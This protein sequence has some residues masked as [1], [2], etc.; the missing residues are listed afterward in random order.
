[1]KLRL[2]GIFALVLLTQLSVSCGGNS[3]KSDSGKNSPKP[4]PSQGTAKVI[5]LA[6]L[7]GRLKWKIG[8]NQNITHQIPPQANSVVAGKAVKVNSSGDMPWSAFTMILF[9]KGNGSYDVLTQKRA[10][11][12]AGVIE[13]PGG[14]L[15]PGQSWAQGAVDEVMQEAGV[16]LTPNDLIFLQLNGPA[17]SQSGHHYGNVNFVAAF[18]NQRPDAPA[19]SSET[20]PTYGHKWL[21]LKATYDEMKKETQTIG[22]R[23]QGKYYASFRG[24]LIHFCQ[25]VLGWN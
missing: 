16:K 13:S 11:K 18:E 14:H 8:T 21:D 10:H 22:K 9:D 12:P 2:S 4:T 24:H 1:M 17:L 25:N 20:D 7:T 19:N 23:N 3:G 5:S 15:R 6:D